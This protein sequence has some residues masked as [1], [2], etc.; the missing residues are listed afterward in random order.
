M[1]EGK[2]EGDYE[3]C[4]DQETEKTDTISSLKIISEVAAEEEAAGIRG[5]RTNE[6]AWETKYAEDAHTSLA[7]VI[8]N[9]GCPHD[10]HKQAHDMKLRIEIGF[11][12][13]AVKYATG[14]ERTRSAAVPPQLGLPPTCF[15]LPGTTED[16]T[17]LMLCDLPSR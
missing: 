7:N 13:A 12:E 9:W 10:F 8:V 15:A 5:T 4:C 2:H 11:L 1:G 17:T 16:V 6:N 14:I 3:L